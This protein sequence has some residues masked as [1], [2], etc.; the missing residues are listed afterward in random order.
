MTRDIHSNMGGWITI[1]SIDTKRGHA[2]QLHQPCKW[3]W[4]IQI[5]TNKRNKLRILTFIEILCT[6][7][8]RS[9]LWPTAT[10]TQ[11]SLWYKCQDVGKWWLS[12]HHGVIYYTKTFGRRD[13]RSPCTKQNAVDRENISQARLIIDSLK[14]IGEDTVMVYL[15]EFNLTKALFCMICINKFIN[16]AEYHNKMNGIGTPGWYKFIRPITV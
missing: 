12:F 7:F 10:T 5:Y 16:W 8:T 11:S 2:N 4:N 14:R 15:H 6:F 3:F 1:Y 9:G 13:T